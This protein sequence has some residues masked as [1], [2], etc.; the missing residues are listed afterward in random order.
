[1]DYDVVVHPGREQVLAQLRKGVLEYCVL[2]ELAKSPS[3]GHVLAGTLSQQGV[4]LTA[5]GA[6]YPVLARLR[7]ADWVVTHWEESASG[8]PRKYYSI[9][10]DGLEALEQFTAIWAEFSKDA[11]RVLSRRKVVDD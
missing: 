5:G 4:L 7:E 2:A 1:M 8:P 9:T 6:L 11:G 3:Y 10:G